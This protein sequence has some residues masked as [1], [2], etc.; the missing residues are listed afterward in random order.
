MSTFIVGTNRFED[1]ET[2][3]AHRGTPVLIIN[4]GE[5]GIKLD[6]RIPVG[7]KLLVIDQNQVAE[8]DAQIVSTPQMVSVVSDDTL[9]VHAVQLA[10]GS[11][12]VDLDLRPLGVAIYTDAGGLFVAGSRLAKNLVQGARVALSLN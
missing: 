9:V 2:L 5:G 3:I 8:G 6:L 7:G 1:C 12:L 4:V 11:V 10:E